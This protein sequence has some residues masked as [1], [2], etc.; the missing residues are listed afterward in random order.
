MSYLLFSPTCTIFVYP[1]F[2]E[3]DVK[4]PTH[5]VNLLFVHLSP[6]Q[7]VVLHS[8]WLFVA[9]STMVTTHSSFSVSTNMV[10][11][12]KDDGNANKSPDALK[13]VGDK[14]PPDTDATRPLS[15]P[16]LA[17]KKVGDKAPPDT[18][19]T[20]PLSTPELS[21]QAQDL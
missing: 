16:E 10:S 12:E 14:A 15:T 11:K 18:D 7:V 1:T 19:A 13:K 3:R 8:I 9:F 6:K 2:Y 21:R 4:I 17:L 20:R 5:P